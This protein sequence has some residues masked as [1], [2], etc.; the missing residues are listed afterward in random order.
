MRLIV[1]LIV[2]TEP[3][4]CDLYTS[5]KGLLCLFFINVCSSKY[6]FYN[7]SQLNMLDNLAKFWVDFHYPYLAHVECWDST[8]SSFDQSNSGPS[9]A[10]DEFCNK[11]LLL[12]RLVLFQALNLKVYFYLRKCH[13]R[14]MVDTFHIWCR[15]DIVSQI[16]KCFPKR[17]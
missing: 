10:F 17:E 14:M 1:L 13:K 2:E 11:F 12:E 6:Y 4:S 8:W 15:I 9:F 5:N 16:Q 7:C 3:F